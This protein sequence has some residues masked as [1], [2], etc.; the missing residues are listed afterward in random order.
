MDSKA[1]LK[2]F[3][4]GIAAAALIGC[5]ETQASDD[6]QTGRSEY[7]LLQYRK[8]AEKWVEALPIGNG[9]MGAMIFGRTSQERIQFNED[10]LW[11]GQPQDY[12]NAG[13]AEVLPELRRLLFEGKQKEA[14]QLAMQ[15]FMS[16]PLRQC[17]FQPFGDLN[18]AFDGHDNP[19]DYRRWLDLDT[20]L[21]GV[22]Y[23]VDGVRYTRE[24]FASYPDRVIVIRLASDA[25]GK[26][27]FKAS[28]SS[29][30]KG[31]EQAAAAGD[32]LS[33]K[34]RVTQRHEGNTESLM[35]FE[36]RLQIRT[37]IGRASCRERV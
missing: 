25:P 24:V 22:S 13:A 11:T 32:V 18:L 27:T 1:F 8:P 36:A 6:V 12:Q 31:S 37:E 2:A 23:T 33:L 14:E 5:Q 15:R 7:W 35:T 16:N 34:G 10:T 19:A 29:P 30:H 20:A 9:H 26:L 28:F 21:S 17:A 4:I 3:C